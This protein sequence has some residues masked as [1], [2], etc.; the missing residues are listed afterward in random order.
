MPETPFEEKVRSTLR[1]EAHKQA[2]DPQTVRPAARRARRRLKRDAVVMAALAAIAI[3]GFIRVGG[4][5]METSTPAATPSL[6]PSPPDNRSEPTS[7]DGSYVIP[8]EGSF[9]NPTNKPIAGRYYVRVVQVSDAGPRVFTV[10]IEKLYEG[11]EAR[12]QAAADGAT[13]TRDA[14]GH[15]IYVV[16]DSPM[17]AQFR[18]DLERPIVYRGADGNWTSLRGHTFGLIRAFDCLPNHISLQDPQRFGWWI[19]VESLPFGGPSIIG[20][21]EGQPNVDGSSSGSACPPS[22]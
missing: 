16:N 11:E 5:F 1:D 10:D 8:R 4:P 15:E 21:R 3:I 22:V 18:L 20:M 19:K 17:L 2:F 9:G 6:V 13:T 7:S 14:T 12:K